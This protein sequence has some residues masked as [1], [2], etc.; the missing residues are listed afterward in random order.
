[1]GRASPP[2]NLIMAAGDGRPTSMFSSKGIL[3]NLQPRPV[4]RHGN[5]HHIKSQVH[6]P[7]ALLFQIII[8]QEA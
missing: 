5:P 3:N 2:A 6:F 4:C 8:G 1:M 7:Q